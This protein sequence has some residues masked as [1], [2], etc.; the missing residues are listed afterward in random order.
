MAQVIMSAVNIPA[1]V[2]I[3]HSHHL[4]VVPLDIDIDTMAPKVHLIDALVTPGRTR[5]LLVANI[6]AKGFDLTPYVDAARR[7][8]LAVVEDWAEGFSGLEYTGH[9]QSD[10]SLFS[11]GPIKYYTAFGGCIAKVV[12]LLITIII[13]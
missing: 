11:F 9:P 10:L 6:Y 5:L 2:H 8:D 13:I 4:K 7:H 12:V 1:I 3:L